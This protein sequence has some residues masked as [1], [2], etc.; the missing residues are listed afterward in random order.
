MRKFF[1][2]RSKKKGEIDVTLPPQKGK[3]RV[4]IQRFSSPFAGGD[5]FFV[6]RS[7]SL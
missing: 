1:C 7:L 5:L 6:L 3:K 4:K 2:A